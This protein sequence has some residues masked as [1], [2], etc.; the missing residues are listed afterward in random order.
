[1]WTAIKSITFNSGPVGW[2]SSMRESPTLRLAVLNG[3]KQ[4]LEYEVSALEPTCR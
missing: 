4:L 1:M 3:G 2:V